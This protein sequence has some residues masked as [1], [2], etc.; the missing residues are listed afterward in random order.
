MD[1][2]DVAAGSRLAETTTQHISSSKHYLLLA[3]AITAS[4]LTEN[5]KLDKLLHC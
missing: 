1:E 3:F 4:M 5:K 2:I